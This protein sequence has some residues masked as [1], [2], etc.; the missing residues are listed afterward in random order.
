MTYTQF[1]PY[2]A[3]LFGKLPLA[4][5]VHILKNYSTSHNT[6]KR[7]GAFKTPFIRKQL[8]PKLKSS[9]TLG[10]ISLTMIYLQHTASM[11]SLFNSLFPKNIPN[12]LL[13]KAAEAMQVT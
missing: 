8:S 9:S 13:Q 10:A 1:F 12:R 3:Y 6:R 7:L 2:L 5:L 11:H 4:R